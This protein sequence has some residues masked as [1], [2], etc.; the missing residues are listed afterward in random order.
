MGSRTHQKSIQNMVM[1]KV[2][3]V[4]MV[5]IMVLTMGYAQNHYC[6]VWIIM[7]MHIPYSSHT[8]HQHMATMAHPNPSETHRPPPNLPPSK[9]PQRRQPASEVSNLRFQN[10]HISVVYNGL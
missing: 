4:I 9:G 6:M 3:M 1:P 8:T 7:V 5:L 10:I 2:T